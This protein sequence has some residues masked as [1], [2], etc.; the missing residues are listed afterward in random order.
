MKNIKIFLSENFHVLV[1]KF[2]LYLKRN[3]FEMS[4]SAEPFEG[5]RPLWKL[6]RRIFYL[7]IG[8]ACYGAL[9]C[10]GKAS[11]SR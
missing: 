5:C 8:K 4:F 1:V 7:R 10:S 6:P 2:S 11:D 3:V 9:C